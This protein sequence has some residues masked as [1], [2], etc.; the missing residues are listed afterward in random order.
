MM[1]LSMIRMGVHL[2]LLPRELTMRT[3]NELFIFTQPAHLQKF[4]GK[5]LESTERDV[6]RAEFVR[7]KLSS[8]KA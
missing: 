7:Q 8:I 3:V 1:M 2:G 4:N 6:R 5:P